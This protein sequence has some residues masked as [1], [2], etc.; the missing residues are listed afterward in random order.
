LSGFVTS[1]GVRFEG[2][3]IWVIAIAIGFALGV[4]LA[5]ATEIRADRERR[6]I[7][8]PGGALSLVL[9]IL[10]FSVKYALGAPAGV[11]PAIA[12]EFL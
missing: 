5:R 2:V 9:I 3:A 6:L 7:R 8:L 4:L 12:A 1:Y 11:R 10:I